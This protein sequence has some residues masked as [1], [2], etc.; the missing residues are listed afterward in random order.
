MKMV[1]FACGLVL[2]QIGLL[3]G[4]VVLTSTSQAADMST[5]SVLGSEPSGATGM[6]NRAPVRVPLTADNNLCH[7]DRHFLEKAV[8]MGQNDARLARLAADRASDP[9]V[10]SLAEQMVIDHQKSNDQLAII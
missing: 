10:K 2:T 1:R 8:Q 5:N 6:L 4:P 9:R 3:L 7:A